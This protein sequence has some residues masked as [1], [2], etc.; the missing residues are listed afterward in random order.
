[1]PVLPRVEPRSIRTERQR[2]QFPDDS[3][4]ARNR[5]RTCLS[6]GQSIVREKRNYLGL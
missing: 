3:R 4:P 6:A 5:I 2:Y 1:M